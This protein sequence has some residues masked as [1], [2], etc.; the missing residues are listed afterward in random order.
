MAA[1][2]VALEQL[3]AASEVRPG[4]AM[5]L[6]VVG[7]E[8]TGE[9]M[10]RFSEGAAAPGFD[11]VIFGE[12]TENKLACGHK[13]HAACAIDAVGRAGHSGYPWLG[14]SANEVLV[15]ALVRVLDADLGSSDRFGNTTVNLGVIAGGVA[16]N[17]IPDRA[18]ATLALRI[19]AGGQET[20]FDIV[21]GRIEEILKDT[22]EEALSMECANGYGPIECNCDVDGKSA[23][24]SLILL[25]CVSRIHRL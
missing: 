24:Q 7:E 15:R 4:D 16:A 17:V 22:D 12:P 25:R 11:A 20:G 14:K 8:T 23:A 3:L 1:Q 5:L 10:R 9:G 2:V 6:F 21:K 13:G 18:S 19:A